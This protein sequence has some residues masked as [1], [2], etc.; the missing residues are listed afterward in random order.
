[1][2]IKAYAKVNI[3]LKITGFKD[4]YHTLLSRFMMV[5]TLYDSII[6]APSI[7]DDFTIEGCGNVPTRHNTIYKAYQALMMHTGNTRL[8]KFFQ[9]HKIV[10]EKNIPS[11]AG[12]G[13]GS[14]DAAAFMKLANQV[15]KLGIDI[16]DLARLGSRVGADVPFFIYDYSS[17]NIKG[18]GEIVEPFDEK[19]LEL[20]IITPSGISCDT[21]LVYKSFR[22][23][24]LQNINP[25]DYTEWEHID[26]KTLLS[27]IGDPARLN[28]LYPAA[29]LTCPKLRELEM[30]SWF[31]SGSG[32]SFFKELS[33]T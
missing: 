18:F 10:V 32:S 5:N 2:K 33:D 1:M 20:E 26:S 23:H 13:G 27:K 9:T 25:D 31:F 16:D 4:G 30:H 28:D 3:F 12:L 14:S 29:L 8:K 6:F 22:K 17:A 24:L 7:N 15:C 19:P 11:Q 21:A